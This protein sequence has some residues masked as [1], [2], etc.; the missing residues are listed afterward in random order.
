MEHDEIKEAVKGMERNIL[1]KQGRVGE[2][3]TEEIRDFLLDTATALD[4]LR[5]VL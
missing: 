2:M 1:E 4:H 5:G 3:K